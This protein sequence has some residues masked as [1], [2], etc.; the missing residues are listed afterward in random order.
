M[1]TC[2]NYKKV[3]I[4]M[5]QFYVF[6]CFNCMD[7]DDPPVF[8]ISLFRRNLCRRPFH[9]QSESSQQRLQ[10]NQVWVFC[11]QNPGR[12]NR[13]NKISRSQSHCWSK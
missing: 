8:T 7:S 3:I 10:L 9:W 4:Y 2:I 12:Q 5:F 11:T 13:K 6:L 1:K